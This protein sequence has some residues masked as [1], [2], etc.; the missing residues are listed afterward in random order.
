MSATIDFTYGCLRQQV[1]IERQVA[2]WHY[3]IVM[4]VVKKYLGILW[5]SCGNVSRQ[6][7][8]LIPL[9]LP[10]ITAPKWGGNQKDT[11]DWLTYFNLSQA[12]SQN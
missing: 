6:L 10:A 8:L 7:K 1:C 2:E 12:F 9:I 5:Q 3:F 4:A 11:S